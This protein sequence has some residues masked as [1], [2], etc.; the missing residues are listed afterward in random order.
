MRVRRPVLC[1]T[2]CG[3]PVSRAGWG[4]GIVGAD[5]DRARLHH[6]Q[7]EHLG[8]AD[9]RRRCRRDRGAARRVDEQARDPEG[10]R[11]GHRARRADRGHRA[12]AVGDR[13]GVLSQ[14]SHIQEQLQSGLASLDPWLRRF[15]VDTTAIKNALSPRAPQS[16]S[17][18]RVV[19]IP[20]VDRLGCL[21]PDCRRCSALFLGTFISF[22]L[23]FYVLEDFVTIAKWIGAHMGLPLDL[24]EGVVRD[25]V[26]SL[27]GYFQGTTFSGLAVAVVIGLAVWALGVPLAIPSPSSRSSPATSRSSG[28]SFPAPS[29]A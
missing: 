29:P 15:G 18:G 27:R 7:L 1:R 25:A 3:P 21:G 12:H 5:P 9:R 6:H 23:L 17:E 4:V 26:D 11:R 24:G 14:A 2:G 13:G 28:R 16:A 20:V 8:A 19:G 22:A 10:P